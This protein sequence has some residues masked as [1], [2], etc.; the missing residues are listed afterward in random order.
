[1]LLRSL[2]L[3]AVA[4]GAVG[5]LVFMLRVGSN[6]PF[7]LLILFAAWVLAP[8]M[9]LATAEVVS[10]RWP[11]RARTVMRVLALV[12]SIVS[13]CVYGA[14]AYGPPR[15]QPAFAFLV[16]PALSWV[17]MAIALLASRTLLHKGK[18]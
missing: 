17:M 18:S 11:V 10:T 5:S 6:A 16:V 1:M 2:A 4:A 13:L 3:L 9:A 8:F 14:V 7:F 15:R 12:V